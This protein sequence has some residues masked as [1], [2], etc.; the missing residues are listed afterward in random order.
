MSSPMAKSS[1]NLKKKRYKSPRQRTKRIIR[2][3]E[4]SIGSLQPEWTSPFSLG[5]PAH[6]FMKF[7]VLLDFMIVSIRGQRSTKLHR[8]DRSSLSVHFAL[9]SLLL[10]ICYTLSLSR[11][12]FYTA[13]ALFSLAIF[14]SFFFC[15]PDPVQSD[16]DAFSPS[17]LHRRREAKERKKRQQQVY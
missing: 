11:S 4:Q 1:L 16:D 12:L 9:F 7:A 6:T 17:K 14:F 5:I 3:S 15:A 13:L 8:P 2:R 10:Y